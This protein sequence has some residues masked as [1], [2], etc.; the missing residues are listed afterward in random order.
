M[1]GDRLLTAQEEAGPAPFVA[2]KGRMAEMVRAFDWA[3]TPLGPA[4]AWPAELKTAV[5][6]IL[7]SAFPAAIVWGSE[8][9]TIYND[10]FRPILGD[11]PEALGRSFAK[12]WA[13][14]WDQIAPILAR[15]WRGEATFIQDFPLV[16]DRGRGPEQAWFTF[17]Y[18]PLRLADGSVAGMIDT[19]M[20][21]TEA[22][23][24]Q[25]ALEV[26]NHEL[27][28]RLKNTLAMV[29]SLAAQSLRRVTDRAAVHAFEDRIV[30]IGH[31]H[32]LLMR[33]DLAAASLEQVIA[34][35]LGPLTQSGQIHWRGEA[36]TVGPQATVGLSL[37]LH[38]LA[39]NAIK[40]GALSTDEGRVDVTWGGVPGALRIAWRESGGPG[41]TP[42]TREGFGSRLMRSG[43]GGARTIS[44]RF[45]PAGFEADLEIADGDLLA[46]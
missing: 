42:P 30:A 17:S 2:G 44:R 35:V 7:E 13:E 18:S 29:Q 4:A 43:A 31:A 39:T 33:Q 1:E 38:E 34:A 41:V 10:A 8:L 46:E 27:Q 16:I 37:I 45:E 22:V 26:L 23:R 15:A 36:V 5:G 3:T 32:D 9:T 14:V 20:E 21:T 12:V 40:H 19:V 6:M 11:K 25:A 28:H 24:A